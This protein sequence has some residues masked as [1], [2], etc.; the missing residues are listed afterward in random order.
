MMRRGMS[1]GKESRFDYGE[2]VKICGN[3]PEKYHPSEIGF[4]CGMID[5]DSDEAIAAYDC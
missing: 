4:V 3:A 1:F 2:V 5:I